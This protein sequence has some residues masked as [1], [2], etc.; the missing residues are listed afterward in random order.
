M[1]RLWAAAEFA[2][3]G[4]YEMFAAHADLARQLVDADR[5]VEMMR[6]PQPRALP[7]IDARAGGSIVVVRRIARHHACDH[8][9][10]VEDGGLGAKAMHFTGVGQFGAETVK[11]V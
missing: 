5:S 8:A 2:A 4:P 10:D 6:D 7:R 11:C 1:I 3:K 9:E